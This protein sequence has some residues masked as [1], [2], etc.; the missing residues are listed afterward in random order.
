VTIEKK[1]NL[2]KGLAVVD[3]LK[4]VTTEWEETR[5]FFVDHFTGFP[6]KRTR[7]PV[8]DVIQQGYRTTDE[9]R[10]RFLQPYT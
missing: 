10:K 1:K 7:C 3:N 4:N 8:W 6:R 5:N 2:G 9:K